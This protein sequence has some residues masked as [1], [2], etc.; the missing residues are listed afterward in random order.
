[1]FCE[2]CEHHQLQNIENPWTGEMESHRLCMANPGD[3]CPATRAME[4]DIA[5]GEVVI[6]CPWCSADLDGK[7]LCNCGYPIERKPMAT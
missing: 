3:I 7:K 6:P 4:K 2:T 5:R 1:M